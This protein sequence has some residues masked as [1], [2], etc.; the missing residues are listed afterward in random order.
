MAGLP[1]QR[2]PEGFRR[3]FV[4]S[5][6]NFLL[7]VLLIGGALLRE[8]PMFWRNAGGY[9]VLLREIVYLVFYPGLLGYFVGVV[10]I[11][12]IAFRLLGAGFRSGGFLL[13][14]SLVQ[15]L[16]LV[17]ILLIILWNNVDNIFHGQPL[18]YHPPV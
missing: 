7:G 3:G 16:L 1:H 11:S 8:N 13:F 12:W 4:W 17:T 18:H 10:G 9:P 2:G 6:L 14:V 15:G 5:T